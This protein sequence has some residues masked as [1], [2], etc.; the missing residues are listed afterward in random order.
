[1]KKIEA[2]SKEL[3]AKRIGPIEISFFAFCSL[4]LALCF[5]LYATCCYAAT[6]HDEYKKIQEEITVHKEKL[7]KAKKKESSVLTEIENMNKQLRTVESDLKKYKSKLMNTEAHIAKVESEI[8]Q[9]KSN[10][11][12]HR[13]WLKRKLR[14]IHKYGY[15]SDIVL[16]FMSADDVSQLMRR[17]KYLQY[18]AAY[19]HSMLNTYKGTIESLTEKEKE[20][21]AL[22]KELLKNKEK[23]KAEEETLA[24]KKKNRESILA[25][26]KKEEVSHSKML[27]ELQEASKKILDIIRESEKADKGKEDTFSAKDFS[28]LKGKLPWPLNGRV[29]IPYGSQKDPQFNTPIFR[30]GTYIQSN[31]DTLA[32]AVHN[33]KVVFAEWFKGYGQLVIVNHGDGYHTLYGSLS[34]I[35]TKVGDIIK[36]KQAVGRV[37]NSGI[38]NSPGLYFELRFKGKPL[39]PVQWLKR[40]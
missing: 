28:G 7:Q 29:A 2:E 9:N 38:M 20:L 14:A 6:P 4:L 32:K 36:G 10:I 21:V 33:G 27:R 15:N 11:E 23:V 22:K 13:D 5:L 26:I 8:S 25:S 40:R 24:G 19:E 16:L 31:N 39:D 1:V 37:G 34:E 3:K 12:K 17:G 18:I 35:F 30:S